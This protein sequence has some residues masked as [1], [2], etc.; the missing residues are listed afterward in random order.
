MRV[1]VPGMSGGRRAGQFRVRALAR[2]RV[3]AYTEVPGG[4]EPWGIEGIMATL[5]RQAGCQD[6]TDRGAGG[7]Q[8]ACGR[9]ATS[10]H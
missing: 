8:A 7:S 10:Y 5:A 1:R 9:G 2:R 3:S 6:V 4:R